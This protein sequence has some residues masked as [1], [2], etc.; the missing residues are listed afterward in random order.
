MSFTKR[1]C[2]FLQLDVRQFLFLF[3][4]PLYRH[5]LDPSQF[6]DG[7]LAVSDLYGL[8]NDLRAVVPRKLLIY[9]PAFHSAAKII[10][11]LQ[12]TVSLLLFHDRCYQHSCPLIERHG[13]HGRGIVGIHLHGLIQFLLTVCFQLVYQIHLPVHKLLGKSVSPFVTV[14]LQ[15]ILLLQFP[16]G[17]SEILQFLHDPGKKEPVFLRSDPVLRQDI[18]PYKLPRAIQYELISVVLSQ[19]LTETFLILFE[20]LPFGDGC[21]IQRM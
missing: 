11:S 3:H 7:S 6:G 1:I 17:L 2:P 18:F 14:I 19:E 8:L 15:D 13:P 9:G 12:D 10:I 21:I 20:I 16:C 5:P 4:A